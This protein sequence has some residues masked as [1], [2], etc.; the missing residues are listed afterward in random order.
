MNA[1]LP[2]SPTPSTSSKALL[3]DCGTKMSRS[4]SQG[5]KQWCLHEPSSVP[6][7]NVYWMFASSRALVTRRRRSS[8][9]LNWSGLSAGRFRAS[10][11]NAL[12]GLKNPLDV[13]LKIFKIFT[14]KFLK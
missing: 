6:P 13:S 11:H 10:R 8:D 1:N 5:M 12:L 14:V 7:Y 4:S 9:I 2:F 3:F